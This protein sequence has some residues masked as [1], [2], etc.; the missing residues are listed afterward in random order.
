VSEL[1]DQASILVVRATALHH[2]LSTRADHFSTVPITTREG[3]KL[4]QLVREL[5]ELVTQLTH[6][7]E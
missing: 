7:V 2:V 6:P 5:A 3:A 4:A 1:G